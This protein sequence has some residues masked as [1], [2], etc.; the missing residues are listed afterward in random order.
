VA[1]KKM[2]KLRTQPRSKAKLAVLTAHTKATKRVR[3]PVLSRESIAAPAVDSWSAFMAQANAM[4]ARSP[5]SGTLALINGAA[6]CTC[7]QGQHPVLEPEQQPD[8][9]VKYRCVCVND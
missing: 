8:G 3:A 2:K 1:T 9:T 7:P 5:F 6:L 4:V